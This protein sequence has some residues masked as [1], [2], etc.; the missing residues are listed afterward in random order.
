MNRADVRFLEALDR[1]LEGFGFGRGRRGRDPASFELF[2]QPELQ[3]AGR[4]FAERD[5]DDL[6][7]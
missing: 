6:L 1:A 7:D 2:A 5:R 4:L 3:L